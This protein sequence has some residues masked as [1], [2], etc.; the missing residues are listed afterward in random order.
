MERGRQ[1][2]DARGGKEGAAER[3]WETQNCK[4]KKK[5]NRKRDICVRELKEEEV[6]QVGRH[7]VRQ[8]CQ[9]ILLSGLDA[10]VL[11]RLVLKWCRVSFGLAR[12]R[13]L[14]ERLW[15]GAS[16]LSP[17]S[18]VSRFIDYGFFSSV[19]TA[20]VLFSFLQSSGCQ[21]HVLQNTNMRSPCTLP[22]A[23]W[24]M[25]WTVGWD[26]SLKTGGFDVDWRWLFSPIKEEP[27]T[28]CAL[29]KQPPS[30]CYVGINKVST[31][32]PQ[33]NRSI[34]SSTNIHQESGPPLLICMRNSISY[35]LKTT[36]F[37]FWSWDREKWS[38]NVVLRW[39]KHSQRCR[40]NFL[41]DQQ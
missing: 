22:N 29:I 41:E 30:N 15:L 2:C 12:L 17:P 14:I 21:P 31:A 6:K 40:F 27:C 36:L 13:L 34:R 33:R 10:A 11:P 16:E 8:G 19:V 28:I 3:R 39:S 37:T 18:E 9:F 23:I 1:R 24:S 20:F 7:R 26:Y 38:R 35:I 4:K 25:L 5:K 32:H